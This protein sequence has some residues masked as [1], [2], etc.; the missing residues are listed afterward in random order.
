MK[1]L[2]CAVTL[3]LAAC[4]VSQAQTLTNL[5]HAAPDG[6]QVQF[7]L[8]DGTVLVQGNSGQDWWKLTPDVTG[9]YVNGTW[10]QVAS[11]ESNYDP[12]AFASQV[13]TD[14]RVLIEGGE[15][16]FGGFELTNLGEIYDPAANTWTPL[17][18]P[19]GWSYIGD[20]PSTMLPNGHFLIGRKLDMQIAD[21]DPSTMNWTLLSFSGKA[22]FNAEEGW[23]LLPGATG[24]VLTA[25]VLDNPN[26]EHYI[27]SE[28]RWLSDGSTVANL[29]GPPEEGCIQYPGGTYCPPGEIGPAILRPNGTVFATGAHHTGAPTGHTAIYTPGANPDEPGTWVAGP[30]FPGNDDA[31]DNFAALLP[32]G[33]VLVEGNSG[34]LYEFDGTN[35]TATLS[36]F[37]EPL[38]VLPT[39]Q[40]L[41]GGSQVY[42]P[43]GSG[44]QI[45]AP[46]VTNV[47]TALQ[48]GQTYRVLG[49]QFSG[50]S[51]AAAFG[52][53]FE[54]A[55]NYPL[56]RLVNNSTGHVFYAKTHGHSTLAVQT[57]S[58]PTFTSFDVPAG[59]ETGAT[60]LYVVTNGIVSNGV[61][62][63]VN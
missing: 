34:R 28:Q 47:P 3:L 23:T 56:V 16:N 32:N 27:Y 35:F 14:G 1:T 41:V 10:T 55:T 42:N 29:Q 50:W 6:A 49:R 31:G 30:N 59:M 18:P 24:V 52:D 58:I 13:L 25:D 38:I 46:I 9:S 20:S 44:L 43:T 2:L 57:H 39:G 4:C 37:G 22:D 36:A 17:T 62:V 45:W 26:S 40:I 8:T 7:L 11:L 51:Q 48:R 15:Y 54:T 60:T 53:E 21:L 19:P 63:T 61:S 12:N 5:T 33:K